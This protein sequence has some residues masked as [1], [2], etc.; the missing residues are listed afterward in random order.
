MKRN[1]Y[2]SIQEFLLVASVLK[3]EQICSMVSVLDI[4][5]RNVVYLS[6]AGGSLRHSHSCLIFFA[7]SGLI[8]NHINDGR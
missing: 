3:Y 6:V 8:Y 4:S 5:T 2:K 7:L 1:I